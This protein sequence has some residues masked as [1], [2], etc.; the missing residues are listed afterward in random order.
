MVDPVP[1]VDL[2]AW[3]RATADE[4]RRTLSTPRYAGLAVTAALAMLTTVVVIDNRRLVGDVVLGGGLSFADRLALFVSLYPG[5]NVVYGPVRTALLLVVVGLFGW[6]LATVARHVAVRGWSTRG[7][8]GSTL[9]LALGLLG[10]GCP[11]C[12]QALVVGVLAMAGGTGLLA[13]LPLGGLEFVLLPVFPL[14]FSIA[15]LS[16]GLRTAREGCRVE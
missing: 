3:L 13:G 6:N 16:R 7:G 9:G 14:A 8:G 10:A 1:D 15:W 5:V 4:G 12:G 11:S 2:A